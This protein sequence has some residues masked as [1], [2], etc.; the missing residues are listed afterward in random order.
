MEKV[1]DMMAEIHVGHERYRGLDSH[2]TGRFRRLTAMLEF[3]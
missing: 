2:R 3:L 1:G